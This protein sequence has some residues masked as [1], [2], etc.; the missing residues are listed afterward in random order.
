MAETNKLLKKAVKSTCKKLTSVP[1]QYPNKT[2]DNMKTS[3]T[4]EKIVKFIENLPYQDNKSMKKTLKRKN[5]SNNSKK[6]H[7]I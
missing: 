7:H 5:D 6:K 2:S 3:K 1:R 4:T